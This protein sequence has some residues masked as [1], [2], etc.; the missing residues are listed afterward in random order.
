MLRLS[1]R[2]TDRHSVPSGGSFLKSFASRRPISWLVVALLLV[3][4]ADVSPRKAHAAD[5]QLG[6]VNLPRSGTV[7][8][9]PTQHEDKL[10]EKFRLA[11][12]EF[13][14]EQTP[15]SEVSDRVGM[16]TVTFP[17]PMVTKSEANNTVHCELFYPV[18]YTHLRAHE[19]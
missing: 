15:L 17:S 2:S 16:S 8:F 18:S 3:T 1:P 5:P 14:F 9:R 19:T 12:H 6:S 13:S 10:Y 7:Q 4:A 11:A